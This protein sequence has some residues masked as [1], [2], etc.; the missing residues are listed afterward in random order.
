MIRVDIGENGTY[1]LRTAGKY[2]ESDVDVKVNIP[3]P[4]IPLP[5]QGAIEITENGTHDVYDYAEAVVNVPNVI[6]EG[7]IKPSGSVNITENGTHD[8]TDKAEVVVNVP[9]GGSDELAESIL[10]RTITGLDDDRFPTVGAYGLAYCADLTRVYLPN[11]NAVGAYAFYGCTALND[12]HIR[13]RIGTSYAA[14]AFN[15]CSALE[16]LDALLRVS[17]T[18]GFSSTFRGCSAL[19]TLIIRNDYVATLGNTLTFQGTPIESGT[20]FIYVPDEL[21]DSYKIASNWA[22]FADQIKPISELG[23]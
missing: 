10:R 6:P 12:V 18:G 3:E 15:G 1:R 21:V 20:G 13:H 7:Y 11:C 8:V 22:M 19:K 5:P 17:S 9:S 23:E 16:R 2:C 4:I 14:N